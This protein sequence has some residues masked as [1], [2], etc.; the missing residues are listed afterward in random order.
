MESLKQD[1]EKERQRHQ[2]SAT[3][4]SPPPTITTSP[5]PSSGQDDDLLSFLDDYNT[6]P[7]PTWQ[8]GKLGTFIISLYTGIY[9]YIY[10]N[11]QCCRWQ[12]LVTSLELVH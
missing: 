4:T 5:P 11:V 10:Y 3:I 9:I 1:Q 8:F 12:D 6:T 7:T 2:S